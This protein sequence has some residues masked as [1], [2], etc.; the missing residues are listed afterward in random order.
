MYKPFRP[1]PRNAFTL[2]ELL[3]VIAVIGILIALLLPAVQAAREAARRT[4]CVN[5]LKQVGIALANYESTFRYYPPSMI[6]NGN[7]ASNVDDYSAFARLLPY[8]EQAPI[9]SSFNAN[10]NEDQL[11]VDGLPAQGMRIAVYMCPSEINDVAKFNT[12][13]TL[14]SYPTTYGVNMGT[15]LVFDPTG[16]TVSSGAF[17][18]NSRLRS[19]DFLDGLSNTLLAAEIKAWSPYYSG[20]TALTAAIPTTTTA[21]CALGASGTAKMGPAYTDNKEHTEWGDGKCIQTGMTTTF[22]PNAPVLCTY[23]GANY[24]VDLAGQTEGKSTT[25][26][27]YAAITA[28]SY[29]PAVVNAVLM[30]GSVRTVADGVDGMIWQAMSTRAGREALRLP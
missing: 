17:Y 19:A 22:P 10:S 25:V 26:P 18:P 21:V 30:D 2:V 16:A 7:T 23:N 14:N 29:H 3:V 1:A 20:A 24:D 11:L 6:W 28:R 12:N 5:N 4:Q 9:G 8:L 13:G 27:T 15:W